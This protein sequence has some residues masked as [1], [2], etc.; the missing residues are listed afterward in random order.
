MWKRFVCV[1]LCMWASLNHHKQS[2]WRN[3][4]LTSFRASILACLKPSDT[5]STSAICSLLGTVMAMELHMKEAWQTLAIG[6]GF[7]RFGW[8]G[9]PYSQAAVHYS[10]TPQWFYMHRVGQDRIYT[11]YVTVHLVISLPR[12]SYIRRIYM[13][14]ANPVHA[15]LVASWFLNMGWVSGTG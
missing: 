7:L 4:N 12:I 3:K 15:W 1:Y 10:I 2:D 9:L 14:L 6:V 11:P 13:V 8:H 5:S